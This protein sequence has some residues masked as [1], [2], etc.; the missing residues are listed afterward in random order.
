LCK[1][2]VVFGDLLIC[3]PCSALAGA[4]ALDRLAAAG[5]HGKNPK[6]MQRALLSFF[7]WPKGAPQLAWRE[8]PTVHGR[9][10][11]PFVMPHLLFGSLHRTRHKFW[12]EVIGGAEGACAE[13]WSECK[14]DPDISRHP[15]LQST[16]AR[17]RTIPL[18]M[19]GDS[20]SFNKNDSLFSIA[21]NSLLGTG[22]TINKRFIF[23]TTESCDVTPSV[24]KD[25]VIPLVGLALQSDLHNFVVLAYRLFT[26][27]RNAVQ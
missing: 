5:N 8:I 16:E 24:H 11:H 2:Q 27:T 23:T 10:A 1:I 3:L 13:F 25:T 14:N 18:G 7:G 9:V 4:V 22:S 12:D 15:G 6:N 21:W 20:A 26:T 17:S 19:H